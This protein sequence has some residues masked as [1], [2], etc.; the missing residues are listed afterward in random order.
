M[1]I[2]QKLLEQQQKQAEEALRNIMAEIL[3]KP[4]RERL[5][6]LKLVKPQLALQLEL[7]LAQLYQAGQIKGK[8]TDAQIVSILTKLS[9]KRE[10]KI[11][12]R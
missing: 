6:N 2:Q 5:A 10:T 9:E 11:I 7:Y 8:L 1:D 12:R 3:D 4:G